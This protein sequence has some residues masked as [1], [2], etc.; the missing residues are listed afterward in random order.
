MEEDLIQVQKMLKV[1]G[2]HIS[3]EVILRYKPLS[4]CTVKEWFNYV[5]IQIEQ[6]VL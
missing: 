5:L 1:A 6:P 2:I 3:Y 4:E